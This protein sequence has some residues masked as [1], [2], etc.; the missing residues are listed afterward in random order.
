MSSG[1][2]GSVPSV[3]IPIAVGIAILEASAL[4]HRVVINKTVVFGSLAAFITAVY[5]AIVVGIGALIGSGGKPNLG[6]SIVATAVV[7][8]A[9][10]PVRER[11]QH[12]ANHLVYGKR[13]TPYEVLAE[14]SGNVA[15]TYATE[16]VLPRMARTVAEGTGAAHAEVWL[17]SGTELRTRR[18][19]AGE[20]A[21][22]GPARAAVDGQLPDFDG[23]DHAVAVRHQGEL[24]GALTVTKPAGE[25]LTPAEAG[26]LNDLA[27]QA[28]LVLRNVGL[29]A[30]LLQRL[31]ELAA[32][33]SAWWPRRTRPEDGWSAI[34]TTA[35]SASW[36]HSRPASV[37]PGRWRGETRWRPRRSWRR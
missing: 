8:V 22:P 32:R 33:G 3:L 6:L 12:F 2:S 19:V 20:R 5:V 29:T 13:A 17:R 21:H 36:W 28:G 18:L 25:P 16:D 37:S 7:A 26:L 31:D 23:V 35:P 15:E 9:F 24:L 34:S 11:V 4:R 10:Q 30:E 27:S 14:F 1:I